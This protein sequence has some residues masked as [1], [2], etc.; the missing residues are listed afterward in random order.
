MM[1]KK[2]KSPSNTTVPVESNQSIGD[3]EKMLEAMEK[4]H[5]KD[6]KR[7]HSSGAVNTSVSY[8]FNLTGNKS[9]NGKFRGIVKVAGN[10]SAVKVPILNETND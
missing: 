7:N 9:K 3:T 4:V 2:K 6:K 8:N 5:N 10:N 1:V